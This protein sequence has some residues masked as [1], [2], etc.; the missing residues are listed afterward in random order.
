MGVKY[1]QVA[2][3]F[4][5][6]LVSVTSGDSIRVALDPLG[7]LLCLG[8]DAFALLLGAAPRI[9]ADIVERGVEVGEL[10]LPLGVALLGLLEQRA[11]GVDVVG[12]R[13]ASI[14]EHLPHR[15]ATEVD[16]NADE[17]GEVHALAQVRHRAV[18]PVCPQGAHRAE[19]ALCLA[20]HEVHHDQRLAGIVEQLRQA[21]VAGGGALVEVDHAQRVVGDRRAA[22]ELAAQGRHL[23]ALLRLSPG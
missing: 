7:G 2:T 12:D 3:R 4:P 21:Q 9:A 13:R 11:R 10:A 1:G 22:R 16:E 18:V 17:H 15:T 5:E 23:L 8:E 14:R 19:V 20:V 6:V